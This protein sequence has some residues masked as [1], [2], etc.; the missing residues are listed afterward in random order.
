MGPWE[1]VVLLV[2]A[3]PA[4]D[5]ID[6]VAVV[7]HLVNESYLAADAGLLQVGPVIKSERKPL[8]REAARFQ[9]AGPEVR[10]ARA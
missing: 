5:P 1:L 6:I 7:D 2:G 3:F 9:R 8:V 4:L 10:R